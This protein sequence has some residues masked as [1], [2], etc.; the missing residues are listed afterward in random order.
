ME[1]VPSELAWVPI[2]ATNYLYIGCFWVSG[3]YKKNK[4]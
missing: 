4:V 3:K 1:T 2:V